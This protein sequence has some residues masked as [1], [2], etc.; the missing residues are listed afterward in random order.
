M[1]CEAC[2]RDATHMCSTC[3]TVFCEST[4]C[5][6]NT[7]CCSKVFTGNIEQLTLLNE[8][9]Q[10]FRY[11]E[12]RYGRLQI[13]LSSITTEIPWETHE[14]ITQFIRVEAG[15]GLLEYVE[16]KTRR[17]VQVKL[18]DGMSAVIPQSVPHRIVNTLGPQ[19]PLK[20]YGIYAKDSNTREWIH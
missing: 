8:E 18:E 2:D 7:Q 6:Q 17:N 5:F 9:Q 14:F 20:L 11:Q 4:H 13:G 15:E 19:R 12:G 16:P 3:Q 1:S 10:Y